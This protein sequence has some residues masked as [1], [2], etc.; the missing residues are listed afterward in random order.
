MLTTFDFKATANTSCRTPISTVVR[1]QNRVGLCTL[2]ATSGCDF[3]SRNRSISSI[4]SELML[5]TSR[6]SNIEGDGPT[7]AMLAVS[8]K[9]DKIAA[10]E[11]EVSIVWDEFLVVA[12]KNDAEKVK[13]IAQDVEKSTATAASKKAAEESKAAFVEDA[14][15]KKDSENELSYTD[16]HSSSVTEPCRSVHP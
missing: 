3:S 12:A 11:T 13:E 8:K 7:R 1:L 14:A 5:G 15:E 10:R 16:I 9:K 4:E 2:N 6:S